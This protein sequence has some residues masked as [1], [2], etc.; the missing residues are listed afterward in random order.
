MNMNRADE[1]L[2]IF[3]STPTSEGGLGFTPRELAWPLS[4]GGITLMAWAM[5]RPLPLPEP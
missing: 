5:V 2:P 3:A 4:A 1:A